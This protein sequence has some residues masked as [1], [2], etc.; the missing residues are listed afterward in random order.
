MII[1]SPNEV[2][3]IELSWVEWCQKIQNGELPYEISADLD[4][5][6]WNC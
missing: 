2:I 5:R 4:P 6:G 3:N 1:P